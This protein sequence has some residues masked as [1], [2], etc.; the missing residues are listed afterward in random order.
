M[1]IEIALAAIRLISAIVGL[2]AQ[3]VRLVVCI[4]N[5]RKDASDKPKPGK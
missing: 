2:A 3:A 4:A 1:V 5:L